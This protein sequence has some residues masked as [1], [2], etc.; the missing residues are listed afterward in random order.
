[1]RR[2]ALALACGAAALC[3]VPAAGAAHW[4]VRGRGWGHGIGMSQDGAEALARHGAGYRRILAQYY[5][6][7]VLAPA[8]EVN[9]RVLLRDDAWSAAIGAR[10]PFTVS[11]AG[12]APQRLP[13]GTYRFD[14][15]LRLR[16]R[17]LHG[18][19]LFSPR[20][21]PLEVDG[22]RYRG[23]LLVTRGGSGID[24]V[25]DVP[26]ESYLRGVVPREMPA[27]WKRAALLAQAVAARTYAFAAVRPAR[28][29]D[30]YADDRSQV[31]GGVAAETAA[32][33]DAVSVTGGLVL[34]WHGRVADV[35]YSASNG[36]CTVAGPRGVP[37]L[38]AARD[39]WDGHTW[40]PIAFSARAVGVGP[41]TSIRIARDRSGRATT[42]RVRTAAGSRSL[43]GAAVARALRLPSTLFSI[44]RAGA[45]A[46]EPPCAPGR[47]LPDVRP[48]AVVPAALAASAVL[49]PS[50]FVA[51][52]VGAGLAVDA[53]RTPQPQPLR[54]VARLPRPLPVA[55]PPT[56]LVAG[57]DDV[58]PHPA[59]GG[60]Q[61]APSVTPQPLPPPAAVAAPPPP[62]PL[63]VHDVALSADDPTS[64]RV[65]WRTSLPA[66]GLVARGTDAPSLWVGTPALGVD[67]TVSLEDL[68]PATAYRLWLRSRDASGRTAAAVLDVTTPPGRRPQPAALLSNDSFFPFLAWD[69]CP[70]QFRPLMA[71]GIN[72]FAGGD[73]F[74]AVD[75]L[76]V[77]G[78]DAFT[79]EAAGDAGSG[80]GL[81]GAYL[82]DELDA[83]LAADQWQSQIASLPDPS[84]QLPTFL[85]L[86]SHFYSGAAPLSFGRDAYPALAA[87]ADVLGFDLYPL[88]EWCN[89]DALH[90]VF[91]A[92]QELVQLAAGKPTYQWIEAATMKCPDAADAVTPETVRAE[93]W[94]AIAGGAHGIGFFPS[95]LGQGLGDEVA[96]TTAE[97][98]DLAPALLAPAAAA[99]SDVPAV[100][101]GARALDGALYVIAVNAGRTPTRATITVPGLT[102]RSAAV[103]GEGRTADP[104][105]PDAFA[106]TFAPLE[107]HV[108]VVAPRTWDGTLPAEPPVDELPANTDV[109]VPY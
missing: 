13:A 94:L 16:G 65:S 53:M 95:N 34:T 24:V 66:D 37:Y 79:V 9:V 42:V 77:L 78:G 40:G 88:Q 12:L 108:Y 57:A 14:A 103:Y 19:V 98:R 76:A 1:M 52:A 2:R 86:T 23:A 74:A 55:S 69:A 102:G 27:S 45:A 44:A 15:S 72:V 6:G 93:T 56:P 47:P 43:S 7:T 81:L 33:D 101:V 20:G 61:P 46:P 8:P 84:P 82:P 54:H 85:T 91:S 49:G 80:P 67:H 36:G 109:P 60:E 99:A 70:E 59:S 96:R 89:P 71:L 62:A 25:D 63:E 75:Q 18:P 28:A 11:A 38:P 107:V 73:C 105:G 106:D 51:A 104:V 32:T 68:Q 64:V 39:P 48:L 3:G 92:Q 4:E 5:P 21:A 29:F 97:A 83:H 100:A 22:V 17:Q 50:A 26:L 90:A 35:F 41:P 10:G 30:L 58:P 31:Y 87:K